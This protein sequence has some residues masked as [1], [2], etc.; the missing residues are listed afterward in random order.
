MM[1]VPR[2]IPFVLVSSSHGAL[3]VNRNDFHMTTESEGFGVGYQ[4]LNTSSFDPEEVNF[5]LGLLLSRRNLV[6][7]GVVAIDCGA[8]I[9]VHTVEWARLMHGWG[10]VVAIEAQEKIYYALAGNL[11]LNNCLNATAHLAAVGRACGEMA[12]PVPDYLR[13]GS[14][15]SLELRL[16]QGTEFIG[17]PIDYRPES[18]RKVRLLTLDSLGLD[19]VDLIK[20]DVEGMEL[21]VLH[22]GLGVIERDKPLLFLEVIK[23]DLGSIQAFLRGQEYRIHHLGNNILA[24]HEADPLT[25]KIVQTPQGLQILR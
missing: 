17:Q 4:I 2:P 14:F 22:G 9:G 11:V 20:I 8:N 21:D 10:E 13:P 12:I 7:P 1:S 6:G 15:G 24:V 16:R 25:P 3:I 19:R 23:S 5:L 18:S